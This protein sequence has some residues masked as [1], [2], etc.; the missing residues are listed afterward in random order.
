[1]ISDSTQNID[2]YVLFTANGNGQGN[3][4]RIEIRAFRTP[5]GQSHRIRKIRQVYVD[6]KGSHA[7]IHYMV[8]TET[9]AIFDLVFDTAKLRWFL[10]QELDDTLSPE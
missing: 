10:V 8:E 4:R 3:G 6:R 9:S 5:S 7:H 2:A 1:M